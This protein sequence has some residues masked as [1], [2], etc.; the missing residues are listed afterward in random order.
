[1]TNAG[2]TVI[3]LHGTGCPGQPSAIALT[4]TTVCYSDSVVLTSDR[5]NYL[6]WSTGDT[7]DTISVST[8]GNYKVTYA[9]SNGCQATSQSVQVQINPA[10][11]VA[12]LNGF[13]TICLGDTARLF[14]KNAATQQWSTG[15]TLDTLAVSPAD[16]TLYT[17]SGTTPLGCSYLDSIQ[18]NIIP[19]DTP[20]VVSN[21]VPADSSLGLSKPVQFSWAPASN[22]SQ[23]DLYIWPDSGTKPN[24]PTISGITSINKTYGGNPLAYAQTFK[25]QIV[26]RNS[27]LEREGPVQTFTLRQ[28][29]DLVVDGIQTPSSIFSGQQLT[30]SWVI[31]NQDDGSTGSTQWDDGVYLSQDTVLDGSD[32]KLGEAGNISFL[33]SGQTYSQSS[34]FTIPQNTAGDFQIIVKTDDQHDLIET[35]DNNNADYDSSNAQLSVSVP[36]QPDLSV[37]SIGNPQAITA[38]NTIP[39]SYEVLNRGDDDAEGTKLTK[40]SGSCGTFYERHWDDAVFISADSNFNL[41]NATQLTTEYIGFR[42]D[43][44]QGISCSFFSGQFVQQ[45]GAS[46]NSASIH[47]GHLLF[48]RSDRLVY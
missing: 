10:P 36:P 40:G 28:L 29:P 33:N 9:D 23:Y 7:T 48:I 31:R 39:V 3:T 14:V 15:D 34:S 1:M 30:V 17:V 20:G 22:A 35:N 8:S 26:A 21:M 45:A 44:F 5:S 13:N 16:T 47:N 24:A 18:I 41:N 19:A 6:T 11:Y 2:D 42:S 46:H 25:W 12:E 4:D 43:S 27:C 32:I 38:G 37:N